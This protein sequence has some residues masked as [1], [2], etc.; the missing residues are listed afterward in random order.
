MIGFL[1]D[2]GSAV[3]IGCRATNIKSN[4]G[5]NVARGLIVPNYV[6][7]GPFHIGYEAVHGLQTEWTHFADWAGSQAVDWDREM[8]DSGRAELVFRLRSRET[9]VLSRRL[10]LG[11]RSDPW[12][13][14]P[15]SRTTVL[16]DRAVLETKVQ[17]ARDWSEHLALHEQ[18]RE[19]VTLS[20]WREVGL[21]RMQAKRLDDPHLT[22]AGTS[23]GEAW[24]PALTYRV[25]RV[26]EDAQT[27]AYLFTLADIGSTGVERWLR[28]RQT[29]SLALDELI[30]LREHPPRSWAGAITTL[31]V[32]IERL[33][34]GL[35]VADGMSATK[36]KSFPQ[37]ITA[38][39][40][41]VA[42]P[43]LSDMD[44]WAERLRLC[45]RGAKHPDSPM[46]DNVVL[47]DTFFDTMLILRVWIAQSL[48]AR[49]KGVPYND[50]HNRHR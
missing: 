20:C 3:L 15:D 35:L 1:D 31:G 47:S 50:P 9:T 10:N 7:I 14:Y 41:R 44:D 25:R 33:G 42:D 6:V 43:P 38:L 16:L 46:P 12:V 28:L 29:H 34:H 26:D 22:L 2:A 23:I 37:Y 39:R 24:R 18:M 30:G 36:S 49:L 40:E 17:K 4:M 11:Y 19:L 27:P 8:M 45:Y 21:R 48:G 13:E 5:L 32:I